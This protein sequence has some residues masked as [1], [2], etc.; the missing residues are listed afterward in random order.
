MINLKS[1]W[2]FS[3][4]RIHGKDKQKKGIKTRTGDTNGLPR[5]TRWNSDWY[6]ILILSL[7]LNS[8][9][10]CWFSIF[11][12][13]AAEINNK[14]KEIQRNKIHKLHTQHQVCTTNPQNPYREN[15]K[16]RLLTIRIPEF[17]FWS[18]RKQCLTRHRSLENQ[19]SS[20]RSCPEV[21][22]TSHS[23]KTVGRRSENK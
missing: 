3:S 20:W 17:H 12:N 14:N 2:G 4:I 16:T 21:V 7:V 23:L 6:F 18:L 11:N 13:R 5:L 1:Q 10:F 19:Q 8:Q 15:L 9:F 22:R